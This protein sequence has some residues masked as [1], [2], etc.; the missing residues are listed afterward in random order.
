MRFCAENALSQDWRTEAVRPI[1]KGTT[2]SDPAGQPKQFAT[3]RDARSDLIQQIEKFCSYCEMKLSTG[4]AVE[5]VQPKSLVPALELQWSNFLLACV[6]CNSRKGAQ[7]VELDDSLWPDRD[8]TI[9]A[10]EYD[11]IRHIVT[12][13]PDLPDE[14]QLL[15]TTL[16]E[17]VGLDH[18]PSEFDE[19]ARFD[20]RRLTWALAIDAKK[21]LWSRPVTER[22][23]IRKRIRNEAIGHGFFSVWMT[24]FADDREMRRLLIEAFRGTASD[25][26][27][28]ETTE[29]IARPGGKL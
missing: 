16:L 13:A 10:F 24:V 6:N 1:E 23:G 8:N 11:P 28:P 29:A 26:F 27:H 20:E 9:R 25:C 18:V 4:A 12:V 15:A 7:H 14:L 2:P 5:H 22:P 21:D 19:D 17:L 3:Y